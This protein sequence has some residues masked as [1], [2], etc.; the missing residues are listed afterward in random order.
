MKTIFKLLSTLSLL[1]FSITINAQTYCIP[2]GDC[3]IGDQ[4]LNFSTT[5]GQTTNISNLNS[6]CSPASYG[7]FTTQIVDVVEGGSFNFTVQA[8]PIYEQGMRL[9]VDWNNNGNFTDP[10]EDIWNSGTFTITPFTSSV[11][12]PLGT[13]PGLKRMRVRCDYY[14]VPTDPCATQFY[15]ETEDYTI[16]VIP[17]GPCSAPPVAGNSTASDTLV[18]SGSNV[19]FGLSGAS[20]GSGQTYQWQIS[21][22]GTT[23][24]NIPGE[25]SIMSNMVVTD[26]SWY[27]CA[28]TCNSQTSFSTPIKIYP[29][30][31]PLS[32]T[33]TINQNVPASATNF[34]SFTAF[35]D[36]INCGGV[37]GP[38]IVNVVSGSGPYVEQVFADDIPGTSAVNTITINGNGNILSHTA[39]NANER[40]TFTLSGTKHLSINN[41]EVV[42]AGNT[43][44]WVF[45]LID[46]TDHITINNCSIIASLTATGTSN[47]GIVAS[48]STTSAITYGNTANNLTITN[49]YIRGGYYAISLNGPGSNNNATGNKIIDNIIEDQRYY[50][51]YLRAQENLEVIGNDLSRPNR[52]NS[53]IYYAILA[54]NGMPGGKIMNNRIHNT[55]DQVLTNTSTI[56]GIAMSTNTTSM[57]A[58]NPLIVANNQLYNMN[59][60]GLLYAIFLS[61]NSHV[62]ILHN[63][64]HI[65]EPNAGGSGNT[66][67]FYTTSTATNCSFRNNIIYM[68]RGNGGTKHMVYLNTAATAINIDNN[69]YFAPNLSDPSVNV[70]YHSTDHATFANWQGANNNAYDQNGI[71]IDPDFVGGAITHF[72]RPQAAPIKAVGDNVQS[73]VPF[74]YEGTPRPT[75]PDPGAYQFEPPAGVDMAIMDYISPTAGC[76]GSQDVIVQVANLA[77]D[78]AQFIRIVWSING[79]PQTPVSVTGPFFVGNL[80][81]VTLGS[82]TLL[83]ATPVNISATIDS[84]FPGPDSDL[85]NN[86]LLLS[87]FRAGLDGT[88]T[89]NQ[90][91]APS[92][93]N[94]SSFSDAVDALNDFGVCG[95]VTFNVVSGTGPYNEQVTFNNINGTSAINTITFNGNGNELTHLSTTTNSRHTVGFNGASHITIDSLKIIAQGSTTSEFGWGVWIGSLSEHNTIRNCE[96][97][98]DT[99][100]TVVNYAGIVMSIDPTNA[101]STTGVAGNFNTIENNTVVGGAYGLTL[102]GNTSTVQGEGNVVLNNTFSH[103]RVYGAYF[104]AQD[105][106]QVKG[107]DFTRGNRSIPTNV[108]NYGMYF[109]QRFTNAEIIGNRYYNSCGGCNAGNTSITYGVYFTGA[110]GLTNQT[111]LFANNMF[112]DFNAGGTAYGIYALTNNFWRYYHN[113]I[114][115]DNPSASTGTV[116]GIYSSGNTGSSEFKNNIVSVDRNGTTVIGVILPTATNSITMDYNGIYVPNHTTG[117]LGTTDHISFANWQTTSFET[118]G[119]DAPPSFADP[120][121]LDYAPTSPAYDQSGENLLAI[122]PNDFFGVPRTTT[123]D[124]GAIEFNPNPCAGPWAFALDS[125]TS[126]SG[127]FNWNSSNTNWVIE[128]GPVG[129]VPGSSAGMQVVPGV[130]SGY[131]LTGLLSNT[132]YDVWVAD[133]CG[134]DTSAWN[135]PVTICT[136]KAND[137][138]IIGLV[139]PADRDCGSANT[140]IE[141]EIRNNAFF[142]ITSLP[143]TVQITGGITQTLN[144][145]YTGNLAMNQSAVVNVG[146]VDLSFGGVLNINAFVNLPND[147]DLSNDSLSLQNIRIVPAEPNI[148]NLPFCAGD[149]N[150]T[151]FGLHL[152]QLVSYAWYDAATGG[153]ILSTND[154]IT[155]PAASL[156]NIWLGYD[157][158]ANQMGNRNYCTSEA[159]STTYGYIQSVNFAGI[160]QVSPV[161]CQTYTDY[162]SSAPAFVLPGNSYPVSID[163]QGCSGGSFT[164]T[165]KVYI[166]LN[167]NGNFTDPGEE[168]FVGT[169]Q[170][171]GM[172]TGMITIPASATPGLTTTMRV[173]TVETTLAANVNPC[174]TY[175]WGETEDYTIE[176]LGAVA[177]SPNRT[178]A[179]ITADSVPVASFTYT[180]LPNLEVEFINTSSPAGTIATWDFGGLGTATG[181]TVFFTFP[182]TNIYNVCLTA[183]NFC[184][185]DNTC[186]AINVYGINVDKFELANLRLFPNPNEGRFSLSFSQD[187]IGNVVIELLDLTGKVVSRELIKN[188]SGDYHNEFDYGNLASG[189]YLMRISTVKGSVTK[190]VVINQ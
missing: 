17:L 183:S 145:T 165:T 78:T 95:P 139:N 32:G 168:V 148:G 52:N 92:A 169:P 142:P 1:L 96:I 158:V 68:N 119:I 176:I 133:V 14:A 49:N 151:L 11:T 88:Y 136:Y 74:D 2:I 97:L 100:T 126:S 79:V 105:N 24:V 107:N 62:Q 87:N 118:N 186:Q 38:V 84:V 120:A 29:F 80:N 21:L 125:T 104:R 44:G 108:T 39:T 77:S 31:A 16:N 25:I 61:N 121:N 178:Q 162:T 46:G 180:I 15:G 6:G 149:A 13:T 35:F 143:I 157:S 91:A 5:G 152:P 89:I 28:L 58:A 3:S 167:G 117:R 175:T 130:N 166:D 33:Y 138:A 70:G 188:F 57:S 150:I 81:N 41:L 47:A 115:L 141:V 112:H 140:P 93:T 147:E 42:A 101:L 54:N 116:Y 137:A 184:D 134:S 173:V 45:H 67:L 36:A 177:C 189:S 163:V 37:N 48:N 7:N 23:Y 94:F 51:M 66:R 55:H 64:I 171:Y 128:W 144:F 159:T 99:T 75:S 86:N 109:T 122:V 154:T 135:G 179:N 127:F 53:T 12:V 113:T 110:S 26:T 9:W 155:V 161:S 185:T 102:M 170:P 160:N 40:N 153:T 103:W 56:Y 18:C 63:T 190:R 90:L 131:E 27:R 132:C 10:G 60:G 114:V 164:H 19:T 111:N 30:G 172:V 156:P 50:G 72:L 124:L 20:F 181:D 73:L 182:Q 83:P 71:Y 146:S 69:V 43:E 123:P 34:T 82:F 8:G 59:G 98:V 4:I 174:G 76:A 65:D 22:N 187:Y 106:L 85:S 129:F